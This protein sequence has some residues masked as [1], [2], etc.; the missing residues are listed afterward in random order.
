ML[1]MFTLVTIKWED[2]NR[3]WYKNELECG[4]IAEII[5]WMAFQTMIEPWIQELRVQ[6][7]HLSFS[8]LL[9]IFQKI[10]KFYENKKFEIYTNIIQ[11]L[12]LI[13]YSFN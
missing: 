1:K 13:Y 6:F 11:F 5:I 12:I 8:K 10:V 2:I 9:I 4:Q 3:M 7:F